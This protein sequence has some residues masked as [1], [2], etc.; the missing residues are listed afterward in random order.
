VIAGGLGMSKQIHQSWLAGTH[1]AG[2]VRN[3]V[4]NSTGAGDAGGTTSL[5]GLE[6]SVSITGANNVATLYGSVG[7]ATNSLSSGTSGTQVGVWS[8]IALSSGGSTGNFFNFYTGGA[9]NGAGNIT[10]AAVGLEIT[11]WL[12]ASTGDITGEIH[13][14]RVQ[15]IGRVAASN[16]YGLRVFDLSTSATGLTAGLRMNLVAGVSK[17]NI[18]LDGTAPSY[19]LSEWGIGIL[20][21][22]STN[23]IVAAST[24]AKSSM[25]IPH[26]VA[27][28][29]P[30]NGDVW[31]TT[32]GLFVRI[33]GATVGPLT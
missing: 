3:V 9:V 23:L 24:T 19:S 20:P 14:V 7:V 22:A 11:P 8:Y 17:F 26:G 31:T 33:N 16:V 13:G 18:Y 29:A 2:T 15:N 12:F 21:S 1:A 10:A 25:R 5:R 27:P 28:S 6:A 30:V 32:A 4:L